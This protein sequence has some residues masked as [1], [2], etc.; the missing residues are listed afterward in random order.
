[1]TIFYRDAKTGIEAGVND[2]GELFLGNSNSGYNLSDTPEHRE[3][4]K[5]DFERYTGRKA[6]PN[7]RR[8]P[9]AIGRS[10]AR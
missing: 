1:M 9:D 3:Y 7:W 4:I 10:T 8:T 6:D 5:R 2:R